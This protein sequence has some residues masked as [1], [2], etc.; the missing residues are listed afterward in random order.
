MI[1]SLLTA[2]NDLLKELGDDL[3]IRPQKKNK[4][5]FLSD[6]P[7]A[8]SGVGV[9]ARFLI[10]GLV[11]TGRFSFF[12]LGGAIKHQDY[13]TVKVNDDFIVKPVD[14]FGTHQM[15]R[16]FLLLEKPD[17]IVI[18]T[19]PRQFIWLWEIEEE[20]HQVCPIAYWHVWDNDPYPAFNK[21]WYDSTDLI[22]CLSYKTFELI[23]PHYPEKTNY[24]PHAFPDNIYYE[25]SAQERESLSQQN[26][27]P[28]ANW[29]KALWINRNATRKL[30]A[31]VLD[32]WKL[33]LEK[34][35]QKHGHKNAVLIMHTDPD[36]PE[37][38]NLL[39]CAE[40]MGL[41]ENVWFST[42]KIGFDRM[43]ILHN[44]CDTVV[45]VSKNEGFGL[46]TLA[47][48]QTGKPI[49]ALKTG[50]ETRQVVDWRDGSEHGVGLDPVKRCL[51]GSQMVPY[52]FEDYAGT[53]EL[54]DAFL[55]IHDLTD[56]EK[57][58]LSKKCKDYVKFEFNFHDVVKKWDETLT[59]CID[60]FKNGNSYQA[61]EV[62]TIDPRS[63][64]L[65]SA[66]LERNPEKLA[67]TNRHHLE[68]EAN[69]TQNYMTTANNPVDEQGKKKM[70]VGNKKIS[71]KAKKET[72]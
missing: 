32:G 47:S 7:L 64:S 29:Y 43:N 6:H 69:K 38:P 28:K 49:I 66:T 18:F 14:G 51:V 15:I 63:L 23:K 61:W 67:E 4:I 8:P 19:D 3:F 48:M 33:F 50:G 54:A 34:L 9:Q 58:A 53:E 5:L 45:N 52:I 1:D 26:F 60:K 25:M 24:I 57:E 36:D 71:S 27:G 20:V 11:S 13:R 10:E 41:Q 70:P 44:L 68:K 65:G 21:P 62:L 42:E 12:C 16:E 59:D 31:D 2:N 46:S 56:E 55:K 17:A 30:P 72:K 37:G 22:N 39:A 35:E 40:L